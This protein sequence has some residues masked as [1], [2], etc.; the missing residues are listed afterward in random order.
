MS[1]KNE[2]E[3][4]K[5]KAI[6]YL[7]SGEN[8]SNT[9]KLVGVNRKTV[10]KWLSKEEFKAEVDSKRRELKSNIE[11]K[12]LLNIDPII[13]RVLDIATHS[14]SDKTA[15]DACTY[16]INR[17][18][19]TPTNKQINMNEEVPKDKDINWDE[20]EQMMD[21]NDSNEDNVIELKDVK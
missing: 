2:L 5:L 15:L 19:G 6:E 1:D 14:K 12:L 18:Y 10:S 9:A 13:N 8:I 3:E 4:K 11:S 17:V 20:L 16:L 21:D 7:A